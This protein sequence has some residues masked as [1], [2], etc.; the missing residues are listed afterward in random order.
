MYV[1]ILQPPSSSGSV[2]DSVTDLPKVI[3]TVAFPGLA[4]RSKIEKAI[5]FTNNKS[6][7]ENIIPTLQFY[8]I[9]II[10]LFRLR[11]KRLS[12]LLK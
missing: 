6:F 2:H 11:R 1:P 8:Q 5:Y 7:V 12:Y 9:E 3:V 4:G 10:Y